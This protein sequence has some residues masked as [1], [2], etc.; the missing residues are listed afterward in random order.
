MKVLRNQFI[1]LLAGVVGAAAL[2]SCGGGGTGTAG[3]PL[4]GSKNTNTATL[5]WIAQGQL[6]P[7]LVP[8]N[9][10]VTVV[11]KLLDPYQ[12]AIPGKVV[13]FYNNAG[14]NVQC[15]TQTTPPTYNPNCS[16]VTDSNGMAQVI[17][18][19]A[20]LNAAGTIYPSVSF[21]VQVIPSQV[22]TTVTPTASAPF[23]FA[24]AVQYAPQTTM[25]SDAIGWSFIPLQ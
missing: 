3:T 21:S 2:A 22:P 16:A 5:Q 12:H 15:F 20:P 14:A 8:M 7:S 19:A 1:I 23:A 4:L 13:T 11:Y 25:I 10:P 9:I 17:L 6:N 24:S 18:Q